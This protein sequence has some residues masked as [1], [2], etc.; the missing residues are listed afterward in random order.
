M[1]SAAVTLQINVAPTDFPHARYTLEHQLGVWAGQVDEVLFV[2]DLHRTE[3]GGRFGEGWEERRGPMERLLEEL[4][5]GRPNARVAE[6]DYSEPAAAAVARLFTGG[7]AIP[8]KDTKGAPY[9]PYLAGLAAARGDL[10]VHMDSD[11]M[12][13]GGSQRWVGEGRELLAAD[14]TLLAC[15][16]LPGPP[17][18]DRRL[19]REAGAPYDFDELAFSFTTFSSRIFMIDRA[20]LTERVCPIPLLGP[21]R[22]VA[23]AKARLHGNPPFRAAE[24]AI[25]AAMV[26]A[27]M[28]RV[29]FL[30]SP[31]GLWSVH[32]PF[33]SAEFY[34][35]LPAI[36]RR[37]EAGAVSDD[38]LGDYELSD[39][40][41][42]WTSARRRARLRR[43][44]A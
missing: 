42:D 12:F 29:D 35:A 44:W 21:V 36:V 22:A 1:G 27:G 24:L 3:R 39:G 34:A 18:P 13:G 9:Y 4:C 6:V 43:I 26:A 30:G 20:R 8:A 7:R 2:Y 15:S 11:L 14:E 40:M 23:A 25:G 17:A 5:A 28:R 32:P 19:H 38:Q 16:P 37:I 10:I 41:F 33:R 31:P